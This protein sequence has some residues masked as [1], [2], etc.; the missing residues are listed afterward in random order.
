MAVGVFAVAITGILGVYLSVQRLNRASASLQ[1]LQQNGR[2]ILEDISKIVR[3]GRIDYARYPGGQVPEPATA[4]LYLLDVE[5]TPVFI[6]RSGESLLVDRGGGTSTYHGR[7]VRVLNFRAYVWPP[8]NPFT[9]APPGPNEQPTVT[10]FLELE[11]N[12]FA[13]DRN[14]AFF[15]TT[16]ATR[17]YP[18]N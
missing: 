13:T 1:A 15:Q 14:Q 5:G 11:S 2:F 10:V 16:V 12:V 7:E 4:N 3:N 17:E 18:Q 6:R 8:T 9:V